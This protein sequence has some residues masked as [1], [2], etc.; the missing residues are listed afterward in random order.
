MLLGLLLLLNQREYRRNRHGIFRINV[1]GF[2]FPV[3]SKIM[4]LTDYQI[5]DIRSLPPSGGKPSRVRFSAQ[6]LMTLRTGR[7]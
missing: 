2:V 5:Q 6:G 4:R 7:P 3:D 1:R